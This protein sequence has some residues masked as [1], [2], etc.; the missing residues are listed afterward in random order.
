MRIRFVG[1]FP[2][3]PHVDGF[4]SNDQANAALESCGAPLRLD[5]ELYNR[6]FLAGIIDGTR[7]GYGT[8]GRSRYKTIFAILAASPWHFF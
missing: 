5:F 3:G 2:N 7:L 4:A 6:R 8:C 1:G